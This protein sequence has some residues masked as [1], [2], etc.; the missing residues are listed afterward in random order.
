[1]FPSLGFPTLHFF[2]VFPVVVLLSGFLRLLCLSLIFL[3]FR[4]VSG[5]SSASV[6][7]PVPTATGSSL[8]AVAVTLWAFCASSPSLSC[9]CI[10]VP[11]RWLLSASL[12]LFLL[13]CSPIP[14]GLLFWGVCPPP[15]PCSFSVCGFGLSTFFV[16]P[17]FFFRLVWLG[18]SSALSSRFPPPSSGSSLVLFWSASLPSF[19]FL[20]LPWLSS[21]SLRLFSLACPCFLMS[22]LRWIT[23]RHLGFL[24]FLASFLVSVSCPPWDSS[25]YYS[26][27]TSFVTRSNL[28]SFATGSSLWA[29]SSLSVVAIVASVSLLLAIFLRSSLVLVFSGF[30]PPGFRS[31]WCFWGLFP[32]SFPVGGFY[33]ANF[34]SLISIRPSTCIAYLRRVC[35][36]SARPFR[37]SAVA[38]QLV[39]CSHSSTD[40]SFPGGYSVSWPWCA[41]HGLLASRSSVPWL[42]LSGCAC[43]SL[44]LSI[45][46]R[47]LRTTLWWVSLFALSPLFSLASGS[48]WSPLLL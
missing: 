14:L 40:G 48:P 23:S 11:L 24:F 15:L 9:T 34:P 7:S 13:S 44:S 1:M 16:L 20:F 42:V 35:R 38:S 6:E 3:L 37:S 2:L 31:F 10:L 4:L 19:S 18:L 41:C 27:S 47:L 43:A 28:S 46:L 17:W 29:E 26:S 22:L 33:S 32:C 36:V 39:R 5:R 25:F 8:W 45:P 21:F 12:L 30:F